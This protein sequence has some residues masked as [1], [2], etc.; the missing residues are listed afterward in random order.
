M[1][2]Q[3]HL[4]RTPTIRFRLMITEQDR[5]DTPTK[6]STQRLMTNS[7]KAMT[8]GSNSTRLTELS[9]TL[10]ELLDNLL[11]RASSTHSDATSLSGARRIPESIYEALPSIIGDIVTRHDYDHAREIALGALLAATSAVL[12][13]L[14]GRYAGKWYGPQIL[15]SVIAAAGSGKGNARVATELVRLI[16]DRLREE[17]RS[18]QE[19]DDDAAEVG[20]IVAADTSAAALV[21]AMNTA[22]WPVLMFE[23]EIDAVVAVLSQEWGQISH[24]L[25]KAFEH[26]PFAVQ[27]KGLSLYIERTELAMFLA[28]TLGQFLRFIPSAENGLFSRVAWLVAEGEESWISP[29]PGRDD[30]DSDAFITAQASLL[31]DLHEALF[32]RE[33]PIDFEL[34]GKQWDL[35]DETYSALKERARTNGFGH[36]LDAVIHRSGVFAFRVAM[37]LTAFRNRERIIDEGD[38]LRTLTAGDEDVLTALILALVHFDHAVRLHARLPVNMP[39]TSSIRNQDARLFYELLPDAF[40]RWE[41]V[42]IGADSDIAKRTVDKYLASYVQDGLLEK[43]GHG[44]YV[45]PGVD[46]TERDFERGSFQSQFSLR[47]ELELENENQ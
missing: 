7:T 25:R 3:V 36:R 42:D 5:M 16:H 41:A 43:P 15:V 29:R 17:C 24:L 9:T 13:R 1:H 26:E 6:S 20:L 47:R 35:I 46:A 40:P 33:G 31:A 22:G 14:R 12:D 18:R 38:Q 37:I 23:S 19:D 8:N 28:G 10:A 2:I 4:Q 11:A 39:P 21:E 30:R 44:R 32:A 27:R 34:T 45:K